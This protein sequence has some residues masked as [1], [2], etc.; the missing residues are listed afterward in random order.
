MLIS[1]NWEDHITIFNAMSGAEIK[2]TN[3]V[4]SELTRDLASKL[5]VDA[6]KDEISCLVYSDHFGLIA[7]GSLKGIL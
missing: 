5:A 2:S 6:S 7:S 3:G 4:V 1:V